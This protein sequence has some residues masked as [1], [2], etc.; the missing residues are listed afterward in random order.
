MV[1]AKGLGPQPSFSMDQQE[2]Q[3]VIK[4]TLQLADIWGGG[5]FL[6][7]RASHSKHL[8][9]SVMENPTVQYGSHW[10]YMP[11]STGVCLVQRGPP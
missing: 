6:G 8:A 1:H 2:P 10:S 7:M 3:P 9:C 4:I 11:L 5:L